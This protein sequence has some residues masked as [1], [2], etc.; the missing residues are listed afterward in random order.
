MVLGEKESPSLATVTVCMPVVALV[1]VA[2]AVVVV[3]LL[4]P[5]P[6]L[7]PPYWAKAKGRVASRTVVKASGCILDVVVDIPFWET[8]EV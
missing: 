6:P 2:V 1:P 5:L 7:P 8:N 3:L 4:L